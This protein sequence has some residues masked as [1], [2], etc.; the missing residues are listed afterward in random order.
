MKKGF[1]LVLNIFCVILFSSCTKTL[2]GEEEPNTAVSNFEVL[3]QDFDQHYGAFGPKKINWKE[4]YSKYRPMVSGNMTNQ[5]LYDV[6][7]QMLDV[8]DDNHVYLRP[9][10]ETGL[11]WYSGGI[12][13]RT[14]VEGY[15]RSVAQKYLTQKVGYNN[16]IEY[17]FFPNNIGYINIKNMENN[18]S[19]YEKTM[20]VVLG[21][22]KDAKGIVIELREN[23]GG[24]IGCRNTLPTGLRR[25]DTCRSV[26]ACAMGLVMM[27]LVRPSIFIQSRLVIF[28]IRSR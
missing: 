16:S 12:L 7:T 14:V 27:T 23:G 28:N 10:K 2:L 20:D 19:S 15:N 13:G 21:A 22:L 18:I 26:P 3:W 25:S 11:P 24:R 17:G 4:Q 1:I 9:T 5:E 6:L 8:L